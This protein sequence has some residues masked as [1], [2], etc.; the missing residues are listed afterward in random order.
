MSAVLSLLGGATFRA[1]MGQIM[2]WLNKR[3]EHKQEIAMLRLQGELDAAQHARNLESLRLQ[4]E[5]GVKEIRV[6]ADAAISQIEA[7]AWKDAVVAAQ[8]PSGI[9]FVDVWN[10]VI[11][12]AFGT[13]CLF[14][15]LKQ[16][17]ADHWIMTAWAMDLVGIVLG[18]YF[19]DR[20]LRKRGQ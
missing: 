1:F 6:K 15:V 11:R 3:Q 4:S 2:T 19:A 16:C 18:F 14:L 7:D 13:L 20:T 17:A 8:K 5:L 9:W 12:P 10:G